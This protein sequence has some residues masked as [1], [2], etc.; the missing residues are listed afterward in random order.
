MLVE[1]NDVPSL[2][3]RS[4]KSWLW[5]ERHRNKQLQSPESQWTCHVCGHLGAS[6]HPRHQNSLRA[7]QTDGE[8]GARMHGRRALSWT[9]RSRIAP[10]SP[11]RLRRWAGSREHMRVAV[12][13]VNKPMCSV[14]ATPEKAERQAVSRARNTASDRSV[15]QSILHAKV[16]Y[17]Y[18]LWHIGPH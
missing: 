13:R 11:W 9:W 5:Q 4:V 7:T 14:R 6:C 17:Q 18:Y 15:L 3:H 2:S 1:V 16:S 12:E 10:A 8:P